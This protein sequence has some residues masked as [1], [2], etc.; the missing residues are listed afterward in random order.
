MSEGLH[1]AEPTGTVGDL[2]EFINGYAFKP[3]DW[4]QDGLPIIRIQNLTDPAKPLNRTLRAVPDKYR[5]E[6]GDLLVS[7]SATL[8]AF[9]WDREPAL[10]NQHIFKVVIDDRVAVKRYAFYLLRFAIEQMS[11]TEHLHGSTMKHINRGPFLSH[12]IVIP[13]LTYQRALADKLDELFSDLDAGVAA[14]ER[15]KANLKRYRASVLKSAV[16]GKLIPQDP[17]DEPA[18][19]LLERIKASRRATITPQPKKA[20]GPR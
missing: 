19:A 4:G 11:R 1:A 3:A 10:L 18:S 8:D 13:S 14:V 5:V 2:G 16:E 17:N 15:A 6:P 20:R 9:I 12:P 7:W